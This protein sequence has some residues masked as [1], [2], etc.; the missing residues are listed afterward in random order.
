[1]RRVLTF[2]CLSLIL[3]STLP[4]SAFSAYPISTVILDA[5]HGG[6]DPGA[7]SDTLLEKELTLDLAFLVG[8]EIEKRS[9]LDVM[10]TRIDDSFVS[11]EDRLALANSVFPGMQ[12]RALVVSL[13]FNASVSEDASGFEVLVKQEARQVPVIVEDAPDW[14]ISYFTTA[15]LQAFQQELNLENLELARS[16]SDS[17]GE[18]FPSSR[19]RGVKEQDIYILGGSIWPAALFEGGFLTN[20]EECLSLSEPGWMEKAAEAIAEGILA[21][22]DE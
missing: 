22:A 16:L 6:Y 7:V 13:H 12:Q 4:A 20:R 5:G 2:A 15:R 10:Y 18:S 1:M 8:D 3:L 19:D 9:N 21:Y 14:R 17:F 11:L